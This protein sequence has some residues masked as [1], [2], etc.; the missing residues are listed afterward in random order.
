MLPFAASQRSEL[1]VEAPDSLTSDSDVYE[2]VVSGNSTLEKAAR[3]E[4]INFQQGISSHRE[5][6]FSQGIPV[7]GRNSS[8]VMR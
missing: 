7:R 5:I 3:M 2:V 1:V 4:D 6:D 8:T